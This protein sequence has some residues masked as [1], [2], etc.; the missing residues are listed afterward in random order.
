MWL[1][2]VGKISAHTVSHAGTQVDVV[3]IVSLLHH[4]A[5]VTFLFTTG[6]GHDSNYVLWLGMSRVTSTQQP[7]GQ[8]QSHDLAE[9]GNV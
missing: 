1:T 7:I 6:N 2:W 3:A 8:N 5:H 4:L 9:G